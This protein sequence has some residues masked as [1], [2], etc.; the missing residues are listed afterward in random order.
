MDLTRREADLALRG[1]EPQE[2]DLICKRV[3][4]FS[5][6]VFAHRSWLDCQEPAPWIGISGP[7]EGYVEGA[8]DRALH[9]ESVVR[10]DSYLA[11]HAAALSGVGRTVLPR[12]WGLRH[13]DLVE[14][15]VGPDAPPPPVRTV[16]LTVHRAL[17][18]VPRIA[19]AWDF[20]AQ[21]MS[22][23]DE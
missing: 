14:L 9:D 4:R 6:G 19:A 1:V 3:A 8:W 10:C 5:M 21:V 13:P 7:F 18:R 22:E 2:P 11:R 12:P 23:L 17:R 15:P 16:Y 20:L